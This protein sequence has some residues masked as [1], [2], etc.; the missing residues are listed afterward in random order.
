[1]K[2]LKIIFLFLLI[3]VLMQFTSCSK[4][5]K[6]D[7]AK[8]SSIDSVD[9]YIQKMKDAASGDSICLNHANKALR[10]AK[11]T[12]PNSKSI[13]EILVH[14]SYLFGNLKLPDSAIASSKELL[15]TSMAKNDSVEIGK[16]GRAHV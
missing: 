16:I 3:F 14:K 10:I 5:E 12:A 15:R 1:M 9:F 6:I 4:K 11:K 8:K 13:E 7:K 2:H